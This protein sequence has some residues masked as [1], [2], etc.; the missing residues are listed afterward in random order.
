[1]GTCAWICTSV[2]L[3]KFFIR[4]FTEIIRLHTGTKHLLEFCI[5]LYYYLYAENIEII[6]I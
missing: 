3:Y 6:I 4:S 2:P 1:M 5:V